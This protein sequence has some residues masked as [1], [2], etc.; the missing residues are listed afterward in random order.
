MGKLTRCKLARE[1]LGYLGLGL[2]GLGMCVARRQRGGRGW[3]GCVA[4]FPF[5][6]VVGN[7]IFLSSFLPSH[8]R[9]LVTF[10]PAMASPGPINVLSSTYPILCVELPPLTPSSRR[11][12]R[13]CLSRLADSCVP[14]LLRRHHCMARVARSGRVCRR[15]S[16]QRCC[17]LLLQVWAPERLHARRSAQSRLPL[18]PTSR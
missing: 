8:P 12:A 4:V 6:L 18:R 7:R 2:P 1:G 11:I 10:S 5:S 14:L 16:L 9:T 17:R 3:R 15:A 13:G